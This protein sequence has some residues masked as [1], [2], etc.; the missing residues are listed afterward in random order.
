MPN[1]EMD[2]GL[3][4]SKMD[5]QLYTVKFRLIIIIY[6]QCHVDHCFG[7]RLFQKWSWVSASLGGG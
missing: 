6:T 3:V 4:V 7:H 5:L 2:L 1:Q